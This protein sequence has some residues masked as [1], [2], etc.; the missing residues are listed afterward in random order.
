MN[1][2]FTFKVFRMLRGGSF[3]GEDEAMRKETNENAAETLG[4]TNRDSLKKRNIHSS[5]VEQNET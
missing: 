3:A 1:N 5:G 4:G 2:P